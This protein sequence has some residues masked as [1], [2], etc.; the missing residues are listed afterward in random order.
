MLHFFKYSKDSNIVNYFHSLKY[1]FSVWMYCDVYNCNGK[2]EIWFYRNHSNMLIWCSIIIGAHIINGYY[3]QC[4]KLVCCLI[5]SLKRWFQDSLI[6]RK[7]NKQHLFYI[8]IYII[9]IITL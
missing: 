2:T 5:F 8:Y 4:W 3:Y 9:I 7:F 6:Y 1:L